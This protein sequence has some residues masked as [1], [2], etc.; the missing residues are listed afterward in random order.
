MKLLKENSYDIVRLYINQVGITIFSLVLYTSVNFI[1]DT[2]LNLKLKVGL[3]VFAT[4][5]YLA[6]IYT[7]AW[8]FGA[9]DK[10]KIDS[11]KLSRVPMKGAIM[12]L[13]ANAPNFILAILTVLMIT[14]Y[15]LGGAEGFYSAFGI[16]NLILRFTNA[17]FL[18]LIQG[19]FSGISD[20]NTSYLWQSV[21][22]FV[23]PLFS[24]AATQ[25]GYALGERNIRILGV[26]GTKFGNNK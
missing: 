11:G 9:K 4:L 5:F 10:I 18:G 13:V 3:S 23:M 14:V 22:Y 20:V 24:V 25:L 6:L 26:V 8:E 17:M 19:V 1:D 16:F 2:A 12:S 15:I 7:A 21:G